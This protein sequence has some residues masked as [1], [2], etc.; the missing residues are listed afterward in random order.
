MLTF[1]VFLRV[2]RRFEIVPSDPVVAPET[3][4]IRHRVYP[5]PERIRSYIYVDIS[6]SE[7]DVLEI[8]RTE[9]LSLLCWPI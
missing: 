5:S 6:L 2:V 9:G 3:V 1:F 8:V 4:D 7:P